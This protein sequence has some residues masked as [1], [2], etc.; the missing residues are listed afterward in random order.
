MVS[1]HTN[2]GNAGTPKGFAS[3]FVSELPTEPENEYDA[4]G[5]MMKVVGE[6][7]VGHI[8]ALCSTWMPPGGS[9]VLYPAHR[10]RGT[11]SVSPDMTHYSIGLMDPQTNEKFR[12]RNQHFLGALG[13]LLDDVHEKVL[14]DKIPTLQ[15]TAR[16]Q[17]KPGSEQWLYLYDEPL[18]SAGEAE[19]IIASVHAA[20]LSDP[21][22]R[23]RIRLGRLPGS[24]PLGKEHRA[25]L[26]DFAGPRYRPP[27]LLGLLGVPEVQYSGGVD[28]IPVD[29]RYLSDDP[30][31][32]WLT[33]NGHV[34]SVQSD[35]WMKVV[36]PWVHKH[37]GQD[38]SGSSYKPPTPDD[39]QRVFNCYH[40][41]GNRTQEFLTWVYDQGGPAVGQIDQAAINRQTKKEAGNAQ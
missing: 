37:T 23:G 15:P 22:S 40:G 34:R 5:F 27:E 33:E 20:G 11:S 24:L 12:R 41:C 29:A 35:G 8:A 36:C 7:P 25:K 10:W 30:V 39:A 17:T 3:A 6:L 14:G 19:T 2:S 1:K 21:G 32:T 18:A 4:T 9:D 28:L 31:V 38:P 26:L 16:V 13:V